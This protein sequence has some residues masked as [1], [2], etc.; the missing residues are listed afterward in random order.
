L[1]R[2]LR[3]RGH[4]RGDNDLR[5]EGTIDGEIT[6]AGALEL[7][8]QAAIRGPVEAESLVVAGALEGD[9]VARRSVTI[10]S[11]GN[12]RGD[13]RAAQVT[14]EE[15]AAFAGLIEADFELPGDLT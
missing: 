10:A 4:V 8:P 11:S 3:V 15:G 12:V 6:V 13:I 1:G 14:I 2:G 9:I 5:I 7:A